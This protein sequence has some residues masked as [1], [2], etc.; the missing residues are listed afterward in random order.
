MLPIR[1]F[2]PTILAICVGACCWG[3]SAAIAAEPADDTKF[4]VETPL[5]ES[6]YA[7]LDPNGDGE[8][9]EEEAEQAV[10]S[11]Q[12][13][14]RTKHPLAADIRKSLDANG[15][16]T[17]DADE[18]RLGVARGKA[19][20]RGVAVEVSEVVK[21]LDIDG[22]EKISAT[23]FR[24]LLQELGPLAILVG[25]KLAQFFNGMDVDRD[26]FITLVEAQR[27]AD[28]LRQQIEQNQQAQ[29]LRRKIRDPL[30]QQAARSIAAYDRNQDL[31]LS[32][33]EARKNKQAADLFLAADTNGDNSLSVDELYEHL[34][35]LRDE[36]QGNKPK[37]EFL[38][39][40]KLQVKKR[41]DQ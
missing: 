24:G 19:H 34:K 37:V 21:H 17:V 1:D 28:Y 27:G 8:I 35:I 15:N 38:P 36:A 2:S 20:Y 3:S 33:I 13:L 16:R 7:L 25:P 4:G 9:S 23:E 11:F 30:Y 29:E 26:G 6:L 18:A 22:D 32:E 5:P 14:A 39:K 12:K 40:E 31:Q 41:N 10:A